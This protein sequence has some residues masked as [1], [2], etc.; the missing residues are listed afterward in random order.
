MQTP[1][2]QTSAPEMMTAVLLLEEIPQ[3]PLAPPKMMMMMRNLK[4]I[5]K[6]LQQHH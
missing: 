5:N 2:N 6:Q 4:N 3:L 1:Q